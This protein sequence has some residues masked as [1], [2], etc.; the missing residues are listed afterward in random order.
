MKNFSKFRSLLKDLLYDSV[1]LT[2]VSYLS[3]VNN[4]EV[5]L[6]VNENGSFKFYYRGDDGSLIFSF[7]SLL[8]FRQTSENM[9]DFESLGYQLIDSCVK[10]EKL[11]KDGLP[12]SYRVVLTCKSGADIFMDVSY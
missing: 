8:S 9:G 1:R 6:L 5:E 3:K 12:K 10:A 11:S 4:A 2:S 7:K